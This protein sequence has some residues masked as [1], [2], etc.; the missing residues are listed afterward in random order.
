MKS[1]HAAENVRRCSF[2]RCQKKA[3]T[4][5]H[6]ELVLGT[7]PASGPSG[8]TQGGAIYVLNALGR[9]APFQASRRRF[10][11]APDPTLISSSSVLAEGRTGQPTL[12]NRRVASRNI[13]CAPD[14]AQGRPAIDGLAPRVFSVRAALLWL[15]PPGRRRPRSL[16]ITGLSTRS[17]ARFEAD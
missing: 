11:R 12:Q 7:E 6:P 10:R 14:S 3:R 4:R 15:H 16:L 13:P 2:G 1:Q 9:R 17:R 8:M 5:R